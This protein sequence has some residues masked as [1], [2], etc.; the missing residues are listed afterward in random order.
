ME[1]LDFCSITTIIKDYCNDEK[2]GAQVNYV[3]KLFHT[4]V[5]GDEEECVSFDDMQVCRWLK[6]QTNLTRPILV[7]YLTS[8]DHQQALKNDI[9]KEIV[10]ILYDKEMAVLKL[11]ELLL[12]DTTISDSQKEKL[13]KRYGTGSDNQIA[14]FIAD[15][16]LF[17]MERKFQRRDAD[18]K[19]LTTGEYSPVISDYIFENDPPSPC[20]YFCGRDVELEKLHE[21]LSE[22]G[23]IFLSGLAG[24]GKSELA[25][26]YAR[27]YKKE[28]TN[29]LYFTYTGNLTDDIANLDFADDLPGESQSERLKKHNRFLR[30]LKNDS[31]IIIDNF[32]TTSDRDGYLSVLLK[33]KCRILFTT[34]S[35][36]C[37][38]D[39][40]ELAEF[41][42]VNDL[43]AL[44]ACFYDKAYEEKETILQIIETVHRHTFVVELA[45]RLLSRGIHSP[46]ELLDKLKEENVNLSS[47][48]NIGMKKDGT[49]HKDSYYGHI[50]TLFALSVLDN[51]QTY[52]MRCLTF[53]SHTGIDAR[54]F[55]MWTDQSDMNT[56]NDL[57]EL[58]FIKN[59]PLYHICLHPMMKEITIADTKPSVSNCSKMLISMQENIF[60]RHGI[61][62]PYTK[63]LFETVGN[64]V[65]SIKKDDIPC[66]LRFLEDAF[67]YIQNYEYE[68]GMRTILKEMETILKDQDITTGRD[69]ALYYDYMASIKLD[70]ERDKKTALALSE[71][72]VNAL[73]PLSETTAM[74]NSNIYS[75]HARIHRSCGDSILALKFCEKSIN[76]LRDYDLDHMNAAVVQIAN[77]ASYLADMHD[78][79]TAL[80]ALNKCKKKVK[81]YNSDICH[82]YAFL[83]ETIAGVCLASGQFAKAV[84][85]Y[86]SALGVY[87]IIWEEQPELIE[88]KILYYTDL[89]RPF[90]INPKPLLDV[91]QN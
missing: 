86:V 46:N 65:S 8:L 11:K 67:V 14:G 79:K 89:L 31:L 10:S 27:K 85:H 76:I 49:S 12:G 55:A 17:A 91:V 30:S 21:M 74:L 84:E 2:L 7:F 37:D 77:Y 43:L 47:T 63:V 6:G 68:D 58:G 42:D 71:K 56:I 3:E 20:R 9:E 61:D 22:K 29:I 25:K 18:K 33:Y 19:L 45:A 15:L 24:I 41:S 23:K 75:N 51:E 66:Y 44:A 39:S 36:F 38:Y 54:L 32:D 78:F 5:Y 16:L 50:H 4:C 70:F 48:D 57:I 1:R 28:Y 69:A 73:P 87:K 81:E 83:E 90:R 62:V 35:S 64:L 34:R 88:N 40:Y 53:I 13:L 59:L 60:I 26:A 82:D 72:A 80:S 52:V